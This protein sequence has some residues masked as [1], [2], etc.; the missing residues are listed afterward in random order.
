MDP[1]TSFSHPT[2]LVPF[3]NPATTSDHHRSARIATDL[4]FNFTCRHNSC[5]FSLGDSTFV[6]LAGLFLGEQIHLIRETDLLVGKHRAVLAHSIFK[7]PD[8]GKNVEIELVDMN[9]VGFRNLAKMN[10]NQY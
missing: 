2:T 6:A 8:M 9:F 4:Y 3:R 10:G 5:G 7:K 1:E